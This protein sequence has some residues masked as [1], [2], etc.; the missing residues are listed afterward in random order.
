MLQTGRPSALGTLPATCDGTMST[1]MDVVES[2]KGRPAAT[3]ALPRGV[4]E[5]CS[6]RSQGKGAV[7]G[8]RQP[9]GWPGVLCARGARK[10]LQAPGQGRRGRPPRRL[11][12]WGDP[13]GFY[14]RSATAQRAPRRATFVR[15]G[16]RTPALR[17]RKP[18]GLFQRVRIA[19]CRATVRSTEECVG[20][21]FRLRPRWRG[22][23]RDDRLGAHG[24]NE[25][26][27]DGSASRGLKRNNGWTGRSLVWLGQ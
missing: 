2:P 9:G 21:A 17:R 1:G 13:T 20:A 12:G 15:V 16:G 14:R 25:V 4:L 23:R 7:G 18:F 27:P 10:V 5:R 3:R 19:A 8:Q 11:G 26:V 6:C 24:T 22:R